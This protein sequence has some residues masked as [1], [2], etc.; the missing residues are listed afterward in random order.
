MGPWG[1]HSPGFGAQQGTKVK[2]LPCSQRWSGYM[3]MAAPWG[4]GLVQLGFELEA[5]AEARLCFSVFCTSCQVYCLPP[6]CEP[7]RRGKACFHRF[8]SFTEGQCAVDGGTSEITLGH[9]GAADPSPP[10]TP[11]GKCLETQ[12]VCG[13][14]S[15]SVPQ[16]G[17]KTVHPEPADRKLG[18]IQ[19]TAYSLLLW[20]SLPFTRSPLG[21]T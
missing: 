2:P 5:N 3:L 15:A 7:S 9:Q 1:K 21:L 16:V 4:W 20:Q 14:S 6:V 19:G 11:L 13:P 12:K 17:P 8:L 10:T 18:A